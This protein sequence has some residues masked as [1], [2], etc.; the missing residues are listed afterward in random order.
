MSQSQIKLIDV[1][2]DGGKSVVHRGW[3]KGESRD[4]T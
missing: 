4:P 2:T 1:L 3:P